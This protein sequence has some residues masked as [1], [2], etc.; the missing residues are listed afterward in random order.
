MMKYVIILGDGMPDYPLE[1]LDGKTPLEY[2]HT[3]NMDNL[4]QRGEMGKVVTIPDNL[5]AGSDVANLSVFGYDP[6][7]YYTGRSPIEAVAMGI[8]LSEKDVTFRCNL[9]T[10]SSEEAYEKKTML[11]YSA[12][13]I[14]SSESELLIQEI[15]E[16]MGSKKFAFYPGVSY[17]HIMVWQNPSE[18]LDCILTPPHDI[19]GKPVGDYLPSGSHGHVLLRFME[20]SDTYLAKHPVNIRRMEKG[21]KPANSIWLWGHGKRP[22]LT[23]FMEKYGISGSVISAVDLIKGLGLCAGLSAE[24]VPGATGN[25][26]TDFSGKARRALEV[27][28]S[29]K[30][31]VYVHV[32][33]PDEAGHRGELETKIRAIEEIDNKVVKEIAFGLND[34]PNYRLM[35]LS[36]HPTPLSLLTHT[37]DAVPFVITH[38]DAEPKNPQGVFSERF[39]SE[40]LFFEK[41][42]KLMDYFINNRS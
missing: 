7:K 42:F 18:E 27:L 37:R 36:D 26:N 14:S 34:F 24:I 1:E 25:I 29:G 32:E 21:L 40:G 23:S 30:D 3:P 12:D 35:V 10:L 20:Q 4:A 9:V 39:A 2:A 38:K 16:K 41:G 33:A 8:D 19:S 17:R 28:H 11:D 13:E 5:P 31:F 15:S 6:N 22:H